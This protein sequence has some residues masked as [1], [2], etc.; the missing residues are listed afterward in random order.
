MSAN[1]T[2]QER[3]D[4]AVNLRWHFACHAAEPT[5]SYDSLGIENAILRVE[6]ILAD[7]LE[8]QHPEPTGHDCGI[9]ADIDAL[10]A[11][12]TGEGS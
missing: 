12:V 4:L 6:A 8:A 9:A 10:V 1:L 7:R 2:E 11:R 5:K 3:R